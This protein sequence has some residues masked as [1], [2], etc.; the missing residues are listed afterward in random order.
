MSVKK[1]EWSYMKTIMKE[2]RLTRNQI[3]LAMERG[4]IRFKEVRN[5]HYSSASPAYLINREDVIKNFEEIKKF[6]K[7]SEEEKA[8]R[9]EYAR[10]SK[11]RKK[12]GFFC[13]RCNEFI[14]VRRDSELFEELAN[15]FISEEAF[16][17]A[18]IIAHYRHIHTSYDE[19]RRNVEDWLEPE[20]LTKW[21]ELINYYKVHKNKMDREERELYIEE[22]RYYKELAAEGAREHFNKIAR[23]LAIE[24]GLLEKS[25]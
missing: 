9:K 21:L 24:D 22:I 7:Y 25:P 4:L 12:L 3:R 20:D 15:G 11:L 18:I 16:R 5:P 14:R 10:R 2:F 6:P 1:G 23:K 19:E 17:E 13:P 8:R